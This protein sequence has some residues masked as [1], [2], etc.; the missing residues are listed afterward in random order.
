MEEDI[1]YGAAREERLKTVALECVANRIGKFA[2][3]HG[4]IMRLGGELNE[5]AE[6]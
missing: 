3:I 2:G 4:L 6:V 5:V 1:A